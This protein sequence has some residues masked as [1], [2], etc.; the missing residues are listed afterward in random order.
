[1]RDLG[2]V[3]DLVR[4]ASNKSLLEAAQD[5]AAQRLLEFDGEQYPSDGCAI[6]LSVLLQQAGIDVPNVFQ[7]LAL[8]HA[9]RERGWTVVPVGRQ[10]VGDIGS[11]CGLTPDHG[12]DHVYLV[13][14]HL[15]QDEMIV[16]DNQRP[17]PHFRFAS[18]R[19]G[20]TPTTF[21]LR[22]AGED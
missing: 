18:G 19:G 4:I 13:L 21:F 14:Q 6:T 9:L 12:R 7:A 20:V 15:N 3:A 22:A 8:G 2:R 17:V 5:V 11:T 10:Q 16:A 1:M